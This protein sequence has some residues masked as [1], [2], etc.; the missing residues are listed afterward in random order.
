[1]PVYRLPLQ[2][3]F[4]PPELAEPSGLLAIGGDLSVERLVLAYRTGIFP[5]YGPE[6]PILWWSPDPRMVLE[7]DELHV[8]RSLRKRVRRGDYR[9]TLDTAFRAVVEAC[10]ATPRPGQEGTWIVDEMI[11]AYVALHEAGVAHSVEAWRDGRLVGGL[12][13]VSVG[14]TFAGESMFARASDASKVAFV[15]L[16][17]Q[18]ERWGIRMVDAQ[19]H[20]EHLARFGAHEVPRAWFL[21][22]LQQLLQVPDRRGPWRFDPDF[23]PLE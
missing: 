23:D 7:V 4:P 10:A 13:G 12:Y 17:R 21:E 9:I 22:Q 2:P 19:M 11:E 16:V 1:M 5:W 15:H 6:Q 14:A 3:E 8:G 20:T 18:L